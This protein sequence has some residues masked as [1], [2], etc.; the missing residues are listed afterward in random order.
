MDKSSSSESSAGW[1]GGEDRFEKKRN[2]LW[3]VFEWTKPPQTLTKHHF[4]C[5][6]SPSFTS[7]S[8]WSKPTDSTVAGDPGRTPGGLT[9]MG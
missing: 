1:G 7:S 8:P 2:I 3:S 6:Y 4:P 5:D 9:V